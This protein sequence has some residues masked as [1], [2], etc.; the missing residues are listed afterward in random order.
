MYYLLIIWSTQIVNFL[1]FIYAVLGK[2]EKLEQLYFKH[3]L[4]LA[5]L[6]NEGKIKRGEKNKTPR[7]A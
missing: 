3:Y 7:K 2:N 4:A 5:K 6:L 1:A